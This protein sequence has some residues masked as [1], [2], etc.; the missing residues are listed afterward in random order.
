MKK[1]FLLGL[2][3][4]LLSACATDGT[5]DPDA[6]ITQDWSV[7]KLYTEAHSELNSRNYTRA[8]K[9]YNLLQS[10]FPYGR[11][12]QQAQLDKAYAYYLDSEKELSL[13]TIKQFEK[14]YPNHPD[15]PYVLYLKGIVLFNEDQSVLGKLSSQD[16]AER[17][18]SAN[19][20]AYIAFSELI[21]RYPDSQYVA[22]ATERMTKIVE[23]LGGH[24]MYVARYYMERGAYLAAIK[25]AQNIIKGFQNT[26]YVEEALAITISAYQKM[27][28]PQLAADSRRVLEA[29]YPNS[30]YLNKDWENANS[31]PWWGFWSKQK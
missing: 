13:A 15:M 23:A 18:P 22:D 17:D 5:Q 3:A 21:R 8:V 20:D 6:Q 10:R 25:R 9:L 1:W 30:Q 4:L 31:G 19:R 11:F 7:E 27:N 2:F 29:N 16:W 12:A 14:D 24:E 28:Q 26:S